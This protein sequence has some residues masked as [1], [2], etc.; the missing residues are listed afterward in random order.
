[1]MV[2]IMMLVLVR[3]RT[4]ALN[5]FTTIVMLSM[6]QCM[7]KLVTK[8]LEVVGFRIER[9]WCWFVELESLRASSRCQPA[10]SPTS[11]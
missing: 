3:F 7:K 5:R 11:T 1:M 9:C 6:F 8:N 10:E 4:C 2:L